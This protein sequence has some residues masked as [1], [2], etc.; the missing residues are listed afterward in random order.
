MT[1]GARIVAAWAL[2]L[3]ALA[4]SAAASDLADLVTSTVPNTTVLD[5]AATKTLSKRGGAY[6]GKATWYDVETWVAGQC[7]EI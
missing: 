4:A 6:S 7:M 3:L 1:T 5:T 2:T